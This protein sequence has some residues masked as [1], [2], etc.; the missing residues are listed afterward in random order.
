MYIRRIII[1][2]VSVEKTHTSEEVKMIKCFTGPMFSDKSAYLV[3]IYEQLW[4]KDIS[5]AFKPEIDSRDG[6]SIKSKNI[7]INQFQLNL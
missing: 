7:L 4:N 1:V 2:I 6:D 5:I 3:E